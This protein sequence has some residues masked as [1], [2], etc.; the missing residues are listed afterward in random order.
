MT[1]NAEKSYRKPLRKNAVRKIRKNPKKNLL[2]IL[3]VTADTAVAEWNMK[4]G[5]DCLKKADSKVEF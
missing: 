2:P 4:H 5:R 3:T 1:E